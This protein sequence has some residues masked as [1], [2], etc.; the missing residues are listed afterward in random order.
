MTDEPASLASPAPPAS[1]ALAAL[2]REHFDFVWRSLRRLGLDAG[3][4]DDGAQEVFLVAARKLAMIE[5][6]KERAYLFGAALRVAADVRKSI[7][8]RREVADEAVADRVDPVPSPEA[9]L[10][11][12]RARAV[13]DDL[14]DELPQDV[15]A[16][17][18]LFE[19]EEL[20]MHEIAILVGA[21]QGT[22]ASRL[23]RGRAL[24]AAAV[25]RRQARAAST[26]TA[27]AA[28][29]AAQTESGR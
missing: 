19:L 1:P 23:R 22:V 26:A 12:R 6:G 2:L 9:L 4:A 7:T 16:V 14:L 25:K 17:F 3:H 27:A 28:A 8:R 11:Q 10:D 15:R 20:E 18:V 29:R 13:L 5:P 24:F 21:H